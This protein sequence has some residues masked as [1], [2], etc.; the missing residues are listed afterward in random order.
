VTT[1]LIAAATDGKVTTAAA[2]DS[3]K[4]WSLTVAWSGISFH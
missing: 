1:L 2:I 4:A 3:G